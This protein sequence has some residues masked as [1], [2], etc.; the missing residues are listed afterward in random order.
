M[1]DS[2]INVV[3]CLFG[4]SQMSTYL[5]DLW[6][7]ILVI[8]L[9][10]PASCC[11]GRVLSHTHKGQV[12]SNPTNPTNYHSLSLTTSHSQLLPLYLPTHTTHAHGESVSVRFRAMNVR[13]ET[14][15]S[16]SFRKITPLPNLL[17]CIV[18]SPIFIEKDPKWRGW[19]HFWILHLRR[20]FHTRDR[21]SSFL[22]F[23]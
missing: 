14:G 1:I 7:E 2:L 5:C 3:F 11:W 17:E 10:T 19:L 18:R 8:S 21:R 20:S 12:L 16:L 23:Q 22:D 13:L 6:C 9:H 4:Y 15:N